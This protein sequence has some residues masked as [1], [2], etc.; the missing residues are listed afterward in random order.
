[1]DGSAFSLRDLL[2]GDAESGGLEHIPILGLDLVEVLVVFSA[3]VDLVGEGEGKI[4]EGS[5]ESRQRDGT[6]VEVGLLEL[7]LGDGLDLGELWWE[8]EREK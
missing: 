3:V 4:S 1:M 8:R 7:V 6:H 2:P 5:A